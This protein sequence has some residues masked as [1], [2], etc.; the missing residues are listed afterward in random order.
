MNS[1]ARSIDKKQHMKPVRPQFKRRR[2]IKL[3]GWLCAALVVLAG[4]AG[5]CAVSPDKLAIEGVSQSFAPGDIVSARTGRPVSFEQLIEDLGRVRIVYVGEQHTLPAHHTIQLE[6]LRALQKIHPDLIVGMEMFDHT[7]QEVLD[8][9]S[10][11][12]LAMDVFLEKVHWYANWRYSHRL[13][14][15]ILEFIKEKKLRL[16]ALNLPPHIP[17]KIRVGGIDHL[18]AEDRRHLPA[19]VDTSRADHKAYVEGIY[20]Q[21][22]AAQHYKFDYFYQAQCVW[23]DTMAEAIARNLDDRVMVVLAGNG[24]IVEKFGIP[25]R[26]FRRTRAPYRTIYPVSAGQ[27]VKWS[28]ADYLWV[29]PDPEAP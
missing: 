13:Y 8:Q 7:Y 23:E 16:V 20:R 25:D 15:E 4:L 3:P 14:A 21:H 6:V 10:A 28:L 19:H 12:Q 18:S 17:P 29:T 9:W 2:G 26:A 11:G 27:T 22:H 5:G 24:H 1:V